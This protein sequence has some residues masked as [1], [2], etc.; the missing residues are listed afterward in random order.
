MTSIRV[1]APDEKSRLQE[2]G[3]LTALAYLADGLIDHAHPYVPQLRDAEA[4]AR[5]AD[6]LAMFDGQDG[7]GSIVGTITLVP[8]GS[9][10]TELA[11]S[12]EYELRMLAVSPMERGR[13]IGRT[14]ARAAMDRA[15]ELGAQRIVL[16]TMD[17]MHAAH[18]LYEKMG[19]AR[20]EDLDWVVEDNAD[21]T[22]SRLDP[23]V[24]AT[25]PSRAQA[26]VR[27]LG[28]SWEP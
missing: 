9:P 24:I 27:L 19:F 1:V 21:G 23:D 16:S 12:G 2:I 6:L 10:F 4:R 11:Q 15:V 8:P 17:T 18:R 20:R 7:A 5:H 22:V 3:E 28:Y 14:L 26:G 13:G 25:E